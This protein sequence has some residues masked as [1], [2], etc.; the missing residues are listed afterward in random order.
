MLISFPVWDGLLCSDGAGGAGDGAP[1]R[2]DG[3]EETLVAPL[4][5]R[6]AL[7]PYLAYISP[8]SRLISRL[9]LAH[10]S[11]ISPQVAPLAA[12]YALPHVSLASLLRARM[13]ATGI[14]P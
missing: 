6:Y 14:Q 3:I 13:H 5:S 8:I 11:P 7:P 9:Y 10:I 2:G 4:A 12:R 1:C